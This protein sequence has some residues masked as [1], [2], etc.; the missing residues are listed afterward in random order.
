MSEVRL[1][2][3]PIDRADDTPIEKQW[4]AFQLVCAIADYD[5]KV[6][7]EMAAQLGLDLPAIK[8]Y[9]IEQSNAA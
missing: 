8:K 7:A 4:D 5:P 2:V 3:W 9:R 6:V 1:N